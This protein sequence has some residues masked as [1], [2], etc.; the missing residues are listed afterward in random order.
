MGSGNGSNF[1]AIVEYI[2]ERNLAVR[3]VAMITDNPRAHIIERARNLGVDAT[4]LDYRGIGNKALY[5]QMLLETLTR[6]EPDLVALAGYMRIVPPEIVRAFSGRMINI[7]PALLPSFP[8]LDAIKQAWDHGVKVTG[9]TVHYIDERVDTGPIIDQAPVIVEPADT[10]E[11][12]EEKI[13]RLEHELYPRVIERILLG[14]K[15][16]I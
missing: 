1:Q 12:L 8:G 16:N 10:L 15:G 14:G 5:N 3:V 11:T 7:H 6:L 13:H 2:R 9:V 4:T